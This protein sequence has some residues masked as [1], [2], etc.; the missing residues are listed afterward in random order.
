VWKALDG[1]GGIEDQDLGVYICL[2]ADP[3]EKREGPHE[4]RRNRAR[5]SEVGQRKQNQLLN[6]VCTGNLGRS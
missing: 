1:S 6:T 3:D 4:D 2:L 5:I